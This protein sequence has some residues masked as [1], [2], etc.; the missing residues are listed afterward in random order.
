[1]LPGKGH[2]AEMNAWPPSE[3]Q[4]SLVYNKLSE[5]YR[6]NLESKNL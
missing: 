2:P 4:V 1:M 3:K 5:S 6:G